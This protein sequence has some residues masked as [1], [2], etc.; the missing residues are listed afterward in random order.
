M[1]SLP[2]DFS[3]V[4]S[5]PIFC[6]PHLFNSTS[7]STPLFYGADGL[8]HCSRHPRVIA[9]SDPD[10]VVLSPT[11]LSIPT[12]LSYHASVVLLSNCSGR[13]INYLCPSLPSH[14]FVPVRS[15]LPVHGNYPAMV[16]LHVLYSYY[17]LLSCF[18]LGCASQRIDVPAEL[19]QACRCLSPQ[20]S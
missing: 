5:V 11:A 20:L 1:R 4:F 18:Y 3:I 12:V 8:F 6:L 14:T 13:L 17:C 15:S 2:F 19:G 7:E 10:V 9:L 16:L